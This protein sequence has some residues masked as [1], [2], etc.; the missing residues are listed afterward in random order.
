MDRT[1]V[2]EFRRRQP[3]SAIGP[4]SDAAALELKKQPEK[5]L[6]M[7]IDAGHVLAGGGRVRV[8]EASGALH[9]LRL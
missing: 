9:G 7:P 6:A 1:L 5:A 2:A 8:E 4:G 3:C